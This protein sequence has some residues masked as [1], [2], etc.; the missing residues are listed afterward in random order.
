M[1]AALA[2]W[3][4]GIHGDLAV[5]MARRE[6][7]RLE[8]R[9]SSILLPHL[10][11]HSTL[12]GGFDRT[13]LLDAARE[14]SDALGLSYK[15]GPG[16]LASDLAELLPGSQPG[17]S[18]SISPDIIGEAFILDMKPEGISRAAR[19][20]GEA[21]FR[22]LTRA[23]QDFFDPYKVRG[24]ER[25]GVDS[26]Q[27]VTWIRSLANEA[28]A[29]DIN[30]LEAISL[31]LPESSLE[32]GPLSAEVEGKLLS[33]SPKANG[34]SQE[35]LAERARLL[36]NYG[37]RLSAIGQ[38][39]AALEAAGE[40]TVIYRQLAAAS[41][42]EFLPYQAMSL[43]NY[44]T[45]LGEVGQQEAALSAARQAV[46][47]YRQLAEARPDT[48]RPDLATS[49]TSYAAKLSHIGQRVEALETSGEAVLIYRQLAIQRPDTS[50]SGLATALN[51]HV[52]ILNEV[53][54]R[55]A[56]FEA[57][58]EA[59]DIRR[60]LATANP[61]AFLP[62][63]AVSLNNYGVMLRESGQQESVMDAMREAV[64]IRRQLAA[65]RPDAFLPSLATS[66]NNYGNWLGEIGE[67]EAALDAVRE[68]VELRR[69]LSSSRPDAFLPDL[70]TSLGDYALRLKDVGQTEAALVAA[71][72]ASVTYRQLATTR[73]D[74]FLPKLA[75]SLA[76][77]ATIIADPVA[78]T[79]LLQEALTVLLPQF[80]KL[81]IAH[82]QLISSIVSHYLKQC[83]DSRIQPDSELLTKILQVLEKLNPETPQGEQD[84]S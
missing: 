82:C 80:L 26:S 37:N 81:P 2:S 44:A 52:N 79:T 73:P 10:A 46:L 25:S 40:A 22:T 59:L 30:L 33:Q 16:D 67:R 8:K 35:T 77:E 47:I 24:E 71:Q 19:R 69:R 65:S 64:E 1:M 75:T 36:S 42:D 27:T 4:G 83:D 38:W 7:T 12:C 17:G 60:K 11:A 58:R 32:L 84:P 48:F 62:D 78:A 23:L 9:S 56:A 28:K 3:D 45:M 66:L 54:Q 55:G 51:N 57:A 50:L 15:N 34:A 6:R 5:E 20:N 70:A 76:A 39:Q 43:N 72:E 41:Q 29:G 31:G 18:G 61:D 13:T 53:G 14:E 21:V 49:L 68:A 74:A 63:L